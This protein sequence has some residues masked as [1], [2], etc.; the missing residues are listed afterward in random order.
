MSK[1]RM[2]SVMPAQHQ[3]SM[4][5]SAN[6]ERSVF[7][8]SHGYKT[9]FNAS[10]LI[11][12]FLDWI[13][14][15]DTM[16]LQAHLLCRLSTPIKPVMDNMFV[17]TFFFFVPYRLVWA[18]FVK[19]MG[20]QEPSTFT[21]FTIPQATVPAGGY[22]VG[23]VQ[24]YLGLPTSIACTGASWTH[25]VLPIRAYMLIY[26]QWFRD[27]NLVPSIVVPL[28]DG[29][30]AW[31]SLTP[32]RRGKR[33]DY[34]TAC[35]PWTQK[36]ASSPTLYAGLTVPVYTNITFGNAV[37]IGSTQALQST[38]RFLNDVG[39]NNIQAA[40][41]GGAALLVDVPTGP[42]INT[43]RQSIQLQ[44]FLERDARGGTR[45][46]EKVF[47]HFGVKS[48]DARLQRAEYLG[49]G[50][51]PMNVTPVAQ[52]APFAVGSAAPNNTVI[53]TLSGFGHSFASGHGFTKSFTEHGLVI[54]LVNVRADLSY[55]QGIERQWSAQ[56]INDMYWPA[57][58]HLGEQAVLNQ[59]IFLA[60]NAAQNIA[61]F[62]YQERYAEYRYKPSRIT[63][64][65]RPYVAGTLAVWNLSENFGALPTLAQT[66][67]EDNTTA[68][69][70][71]VLAVN[72]EPDIIM[73][74][75]MQYRCARP[76]PVY[77]VPGLIDH[78]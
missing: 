39:A 15:G 70:D 38:P 32:Q 18:N 10:Y 29:P 16:S 47:A 27:E 31:G 59:E 51:S 67:I 3:F 12:F 2:P 35:L 57:F 25:S 48:P 41:V 63:G 19:M 65:F 78:F 74:S 62:G 21:V 40:G 69:L 34:F 8:R 30:D 66:F 54:G 20:E 33:H 46:T 64:L 11:P 55:A 58:A 75:Y 28:T 49:G 37:S 73:D 77:G 7:D 36:S 4:V 23:S 71:R 22:A 76:M 56:T 6:I 61:V 53:G 60:D 45:Y 68:V 44:R 9:T 43:L 17:E 72:S 50:S 42:T 5:P 52:S 14:P 26:N 1:V 24:D 13:L